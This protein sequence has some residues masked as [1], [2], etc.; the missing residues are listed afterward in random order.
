MDWCE[1][2]MPFA[3]YDLAWPPGSERSR[4]LFYEMWSHL[5][6][7]VLHYVRGGPERKDVNKILEA[8]KECWAY[9]EL[10]ERVSSL[11]TVLW[12]SKSQMHYRCNRLHVQAPV[13]RETTD[14]ASSHWP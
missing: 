8:M 7:I 1:T 10:V 12:I 9:S 4:A 5:S 14:M 2:I 11:H 13:G 6:K 3:S